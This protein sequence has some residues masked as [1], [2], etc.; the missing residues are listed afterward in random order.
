MPWQGNAREIVKYAQGKMDRKQER[1]EEE[2][3]ELTR[4]T[5]VG[6]EDRIQRR[7]EHTMRMQ[8][9]ESVKC[10]KDKARVSQ[11]W[12]IHRTACGQTSLG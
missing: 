6:D 11:L 5:L 3:L 9:E 12:H 1:H 10:N 7:Y 8:Q 2:I 4:R